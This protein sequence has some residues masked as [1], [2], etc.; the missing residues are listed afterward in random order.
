MDTISKQSQAIELMLN[1]DSAVSI[2][3]ESVCLQN[4]A[5]MPVTKQKL[6]LATYLGDTIHISGCLQAN[7]TYILYLL[8]FTWHIA[9]L[10]SGVT[11]SHMPGG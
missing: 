9:V 11:S 5:N 8:S 10:L 6:H 7:V 3:P 4:F 1:T 2:L